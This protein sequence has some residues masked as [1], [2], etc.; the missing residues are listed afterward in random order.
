[1]MDKFWGHQI[2]LPNIAKQLK[3]VEAYKQCKKQMQV[4]EEAA[5]ALD[6]LMASL[7]HQAFTTGFAE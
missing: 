1:M 5:K 2:S 7:Q 4:H 6:K 3:F